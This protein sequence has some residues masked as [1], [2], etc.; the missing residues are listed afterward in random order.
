MARLVQIENSLKKTRSK[1]SNLDAKNIGKSAE[2]LRKE[3]HE[4]FS[5]ARY[6]ILQ[7]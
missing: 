2:E 5:N 1:M 4:L 3:Q 7:N 6:E